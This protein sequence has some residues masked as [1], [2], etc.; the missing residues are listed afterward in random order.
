V[1]SSAVNV[2]NPTTNATA[3]QLAQ[4]AANVAGTIFNQC[5][6][7]KMYEDVYTAIADLA[8]AINC[9][10][11]AGLTINNTTASSV[12]TVTVRNAFA[13]GASAVVPATMSSRTV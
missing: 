6:Q 4:I 11:Q 13:L 12:T 10:A 9:L 5:T 1:A 8:F 7:G 3:V 2:P